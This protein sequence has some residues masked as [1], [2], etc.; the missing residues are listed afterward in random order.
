[1]VQIGA[2]KE[3]SVITQ[4][5]ESAFPI[6]NNGESASI[7]FDPND[8]PVIKIAATALS[9]DISLVTG[10]K[11]D[12]YTEANN[13]PSPPII[14]G[15][16]GQCRHIDRLFENK[17]IQPDIRGKWET[18]LITVVEQPTENIARALV[19][20]GSDPRGTAFGVF[21]LSKQIGVSPWIW[22][23]DVQPQKRSS[24]FVRKN[25]TMQ[26][27]PSV[28]YRGI[29]LNDEDWGLEPWAARNIDND[30]KDI[31]P[32]TYARI[33]ELLLRLKANL[34]WPAMH[35]CTKA[36]YYY[37]DNPKVADQYAIVVG[38]SHCEP[39]L[40]N[41]VDEWKRNFRQEYGKA[42]GP[43]RYDQNR[44]EIARYWNDRVL[45]SRHYESVYTI[46]MRGIHDSSMPGPEDMEAQIELLNQVITEQR[47]MLA[48]GL[49][50]PID[51]IPQIFCP[52]K[53]VL[54][55]YQAGAEIPDD[56]TIVWADDNHGYIRQLS[57]PEEQQR[58]GRSGVYYHLSYWGAPEDYLWLS[59]I[60]P[61][62]ISYEMSKAYAY[63]ADRL[64]VFNV[65]DIKP[66]EMETEF[67][68]ELAWD[69]SAWPP[70]EAHKYSKHWAIRAFGPELANAVAEIKQDYYRLAQAGKPEHINLVEFSREEAEQRLS[71]YQR[72]AQKADE[73][74]KRVPASNKDAYFQLIQYPVRC[75]ALMNEKWLCA[76]M[77]LEPGL[78]ESVATDYADKARSAYS[79]IKQLTDYYNK[80]V[81]DG[82]WNGMMSWNPRHRPVYQ[83]P[84][85]RM[86]GDKSSERFR[87]NETVVVIRADQFTEK[88]QGLHVLQGLGVSGVSITMLPFT[89]PSIE[90]QGYQ[91]APHVDYEVRLPKGERKIEVVCLP[92]H[93]IHE[94][95]GLRYA[96]S[97]D[98]G[99]PHIENVHSPSKTSD[100]GTNVLRGYSSASFSFTLDQ[101]MI[102]ML[103]IAILDAG[104]AIS[105]IRIY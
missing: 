16:R 61:S 55:L 97:V 52:Y 50:R 79:Q 20:V 24:L 105:E 25:T 43:W 75:A 88:S 91:D 73:L 23:A 62:L 13:I 90:D 66:A 85:T 10:V 37:K 98:G 103:R 58:S 54:D 59:S 1:M 49:K 14:V 2:R 28:K 22:W 39:M 92:T 5:Q 102:V 38:S 71:D 89:K 100:W 32:K 56:V 77:S 46:G 70:S 93:R 41:N 60:S 95:R 78:S 3:I 74:G 45:E 76:K 29:F 6:V 101:D 65:G 87:T 51:E 64:W 42:P 18:F 33:F 44:D 8:A 94:G 84:Q 48:A 40:R 12:L 80:E 17:T 30:V 4:P 36:F 86:S 99:A 27:P 21:E 35:P 81:S 104:L 72:I 63:G 19:I 11:P 9:H 7:L 47:A 26:G 68:M 31:G 67:A 15:T 34:L 83:M 82:K 69:V 53:E 57:T 96:I